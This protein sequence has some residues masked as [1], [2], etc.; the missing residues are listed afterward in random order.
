MIM[1]N[2]FFF[3]SHQGEPEYQDALGRGD[4][5]G[6]KIMITSFLNLG[7]F[8]V[9]SLFWP[10]KAVL[11]IFLSLSWSSLSFSFIVPLHELILSSWLMITM[12]I[13]AHQA[14]V[15]LRETILKVDKKVYITPHYGWS[16][17]NLSRL[18]LLHTEPFYLKS[19]P[20]WIFVNNN[21]KDVMLTTLIWMTH[22]TLYFNRFG[23]LPPAP[24][25]TFLF[26][27]HQRSVVV[28][29]L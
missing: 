2:L 3:T 18:C 5:P 22:E 20:A 12:T 28:V 16:V 25:S 23:L 1:F 14:D 6:T 24:R 15:E 26:Q 27:K 11:V 4:G 21:N 8:Y 29:S 17:Q 10:C 7:T 13:F 19:G 9:F